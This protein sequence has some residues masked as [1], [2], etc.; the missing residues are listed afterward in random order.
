MD[1]INTQSGKVTTMSPWQTTASPRSSGRASRA[2]G[3]FWNRLENKRT[4]ADNQHVTD[5]TSFIDFIAAGF[6]HRLGAK[7]PDPGHG[8]E[9]DAS[10]SDLRRFQRPP[11]TIGP[12]F[13]DVGG[14]RLHGVRT[15][16]RRGVLEKEKRPPSRGGLPEGRLL[17]VFDLRCLR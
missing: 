14:I 12:P 8:H 11:Y 1:T 10:G 6:K 4:R 5:V 9:I 7:R 17:I 2:H 15:R 13:P 3:E 16:R